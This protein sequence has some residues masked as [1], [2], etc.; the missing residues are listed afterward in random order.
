MGTILP[1]EF[2]SP[3]ITRPT[4]D[5]L[6]L[7]VRG[8]LS[9]R[10]GSVLADLSKKGNNGTIYGATYVNTP[11]GNSVLSFDGID[12]YC[13]MGNDESLDITDEITVEAW[14]KGSALSDKEITERWQNT[15]YLYGY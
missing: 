5:S 11:L 3:G 6:V 4:D 2:S 8:Q 14:V 1:K 9:R 15:K 13:D 7:W 10:K 12:D